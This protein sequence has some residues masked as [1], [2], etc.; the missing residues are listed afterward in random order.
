MLRDD[1]P[2][3]FFDFHAKKQRD[4]IADARQVRHDAGT[5]ELGQ[6][7]PGDRNTQKADGSAAMGFDYASFACSSMLKMDT[8]PITLVSCVHAR[9]IGGLR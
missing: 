5:Q 6:F 1:G 4:I 8:T 2:D 9:T 3:D 7:T